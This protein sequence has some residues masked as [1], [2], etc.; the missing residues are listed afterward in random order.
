M[1]IQ[2]SVSSPKKPVFSKM[3]TLNRNETSQTDRL[4]NNYTKSKDVTPL[5]D[6]TIVEYSN[7]NN[8]IEMF[9]NRRH[10]HNSIDAGCQT[11]NDEVD[12]L[13]IGYSLKKNKFNR[14]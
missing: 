10:S 12:N 7:F 9:C 4:S 5:H 1:D 13:P 2:V 14:L 8:L 6:K 3:S 11:A